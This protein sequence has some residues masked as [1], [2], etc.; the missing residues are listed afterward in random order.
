MSSR[1]G[2]GGSLPRSNRTA[3]VL[4][5][6]IGL[7]GSALRWLV[8]VALPFPTIA[9]GPTTPEDWQTLY[10]ACLEGAKT[11][12][13]DRQLSADF[14]AAFCGCFLLLDSAIATKGLQALDAEEKAIL[15]KVLQGNFYCSQK[16]TR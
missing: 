13:R 3:G 10:N 7:A 12:A 8:I 9:A 6:G 4:F 15:G 2:F 14:P 11:V 16:V 1:S 5:R